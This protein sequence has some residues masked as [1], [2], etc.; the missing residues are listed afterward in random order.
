MS[1][2]PIHY[3]PIS[4]L[5]RRYRNRS[6]SPVEVTR[7]F[8][9]RIQTV[10]P[11][12]RSFLHL[13]PERAMEEA[14]QAE[15]AWLKRDSPGPLCGV[16]YAVKDL[17]DVRGVPTTAGTHLRKKALARS[18]SFAVQRLTKAGMILIGK[19]HTVQFA[20]SGVG[21]NHDQGTPLNPWKQQPHVPGGSSSGSAAAVA[22]GLVPAALGTD[23]GGSVRIPAS[24]CG[25][26]G[27]KTTFGRI[28]LAGIYPLNPRL[29][30]I[31]PLTRT[32]EDAA[33]MAQALQGPG[34][35]DE[36]PLAAA[37]TQDL[38][39][40]LTQ[41]IRGL[42]LALAEKVF[43]DQADPETASAV[44]RAA[45]I[46]QSLGATV[47]SLALPEAAEILA[48]PHTPLMTAAEGCVVNASF[49]DHHLNALDPVVAQRLLKGRG[50]LATD[51]LATWRQWRS[52]QESALKRLRQVEALIVPTT[53]I[54]ARPLAE[55]DQS[56]E[57]H[58]FFNGRYLR[59]TFI[60][61]ILNFSAL[62]LSCGFTSQGLPIGLM[63]Y[64]KP[65]QEHTA[66]RL[67][68]AYEQATPWHCSHPDL[69]WAE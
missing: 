40:N 14:R 43:F 15:Q 68:Y 65:D 30:S 24:L 3:L 69:S 62:S 35:R 46:F 47:E 1:D 41:G 44:R 67:A 60:G 22:A 13:T 66:L 19:T 38:R 5:T 48:N 31:G 37:P 7:H 4:E 20:F 45:R 52:L 59:N 36:G 8:L 42:R 26:V 32:V 50:L 29:D 57:T 9:E 61:N 10:D 34:P 2:Q 18:D 54:P 39:R 21:I 64:T 12:V 11:R 25:I 28:R 17:F 49:L 16:P 27:L 63:L 55:V 56:L 6:L 33:L 58:Q 51:Y 23:T 53:M